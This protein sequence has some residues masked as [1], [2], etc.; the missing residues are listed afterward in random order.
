MRDLQTGALSV[1]RFSLFIAFVSVFALSAS[2]GKCLIGHGWDFLDATTD[3]VHRNRA[4][5][6][7]TG[8][9]G[10]LL[11]VD[12]VKDD[13]SFLCGRSIMR[14]PAYSMSGFKGVDAKLREITACDGLRESL[15]LTMLVSNKRIAWDDDAAWS[16]ISNNMA[17][18]AR[19]ARAGGLKG[20]AI[21]H[22]DYYKTRQFNRLPDD[23]A[24]TWELAR[25]R[26]RAVFGGL[27]AEFPDS[28]LL[29]FWLFSDSGVLWKAFLNGMLDVAPS[30]VR[31][32]DG[33]ENCG[34]ECD[35]L[36]DGFRSD[37][38]FMSRRLRE[39]AL[40]GNRAKY[41]M[42]FSASFGQY[43]DMY[44]NKEG[45]RYYFGPLGG[46]RLAR[47]EDNLCEAV[48]YSDDLVW[49]YA[50]RGTWVD[51]D[52][53]RT[54]K[55][56][57]PTW[58]SRLPGLSKVLRIAAGDGSGIADDVARGVLTN[59]IVNPGCDSVAGRRLPFYGWSRLGDKF[60]D[61]IF[62]HDPAVGRTSP[63]SLKLAG[64]GCFCLGAKGLKPGESVYLQVW[65][66][67]EG[68]VGFDWQTGKT[69]HWYYRRDFLR[70]TGRRDGQWREIF[71]RLRVP[72]GVDSLNFSLSGFNS[73]PENPVWFD[74]CAVY[75]KTIGRR[76]AAH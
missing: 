68:S 60:S 30:G 59:L 35:A 49:V 61:R 36:K 50:E 10:V 69:R 56:G 21:D 38:W 24:G 23:P 51:W 18:I 7:A 8:L 58:E 32:I 67:G 29:G 55:L 76:T 46:S 2:A 17:V 40:P 66:K 52:D 44:T 39:Q 11:P 65:V 14:N 63:G 27:F 70:P 57:R 9:D 34:Y 33:N 72:E 42:V 48:R 16:T 15:A 1:R 64:D 5:F 75:V 6:A 45:S 12:G 31:F 25:A 73:C 74:D 3:D 22:E 20:V 26:G 54:V 62:F 71:A 4:K 43:L 19:L 37:F 28:K 41:D 13:G 47:L 53:K